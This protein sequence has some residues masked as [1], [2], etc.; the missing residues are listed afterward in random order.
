[1]ATTSTAMSTS[2]AGQTWR[3]RMPPDDRAVVLRPAAVK[4]WPAGGRQPEADEAE[5][6]D[7]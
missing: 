7:R 2:G 4:E 6:A 3:Q 5:H 1:M